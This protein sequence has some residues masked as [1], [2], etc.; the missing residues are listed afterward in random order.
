MTSRERR[1][2]ER[3]TTSTNR[4]APELDEQGQTGTVQRALWIDATRGGH[5]YGAVGRGRVSRVGRR[6]GYA[7]GAFDVDG[8][9]DGSLCTLLADDEDGEAREG[10]STEEV[11]EEVSLET[12]AS[13]V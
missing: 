3:R 7:A 2:L 9:G 6:G 5:G 4:A 10:A 11:D 12:S 1:R 8:N 13:S